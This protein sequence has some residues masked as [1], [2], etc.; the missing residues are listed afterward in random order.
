MAAEH[1][2]EFFDGNDQQSDL[3]LQ[4][5]IYKLTVFD[6]VGCFALQMD[7]L[8]PTFRDRMSHFEK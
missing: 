4:T 5:N 1:R 2:V 6:L 3:A 8:L 7:G